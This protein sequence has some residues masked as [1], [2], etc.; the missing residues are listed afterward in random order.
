MKAQ[1]RDNILIEVATDVKWIKRQREEDVSFL[2]HS[3]SKIEAHLSDLNDNVSKN[4]ARSIANKR[5][6]TLIGL[7][8]IPVIL[9]AFGIY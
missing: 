5:I 2:Q 7:G 4:T 3:L 9:K 8:C 1:E 6:I